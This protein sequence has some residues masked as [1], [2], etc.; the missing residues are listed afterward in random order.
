MTGSFWL[1]PVEVLQARQAEYIGNPLQSTVTFDKRL[2]TR[3][4]GPLVSVRLSG[5]RPDPS[6]RSILGSLIKKRRKKIRKHK[7]K[8]RRRANRHKKRERYKV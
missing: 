6:W 7:L 8:K 5:L 1:S 3:Y 2:Q 4:L